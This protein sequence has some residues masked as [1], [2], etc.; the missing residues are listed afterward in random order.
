MA[1]AIFAVASAVSKSMGIKVSLLSDLRT[2]RRVM[3]IMGDVDP[4]SSHTAEVRRAAIRS[5]ASEK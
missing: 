3:A 5:T 1:F 2:M 4:A